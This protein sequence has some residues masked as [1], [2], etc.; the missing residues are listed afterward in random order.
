MIEVQGICS[1]MSVK[2]KITWRE[3]VKGKSTECFVENH[4]GPEPGLHVSHVRDTA[5]LQSG[6]YHTC[7]H[8]EA[9]RVWFA[10]G[11]TT[12]DR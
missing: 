10:Q 11:L 6:Y 1:F 12:D 2:K 4:C 3:R 9:W 5:S 7:V 8:T